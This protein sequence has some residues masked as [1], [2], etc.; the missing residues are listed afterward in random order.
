MCE[1]VAIEGVKQVALL[2]GKLLRVLSVEHG[3]RV[4]FVLVGHAHIVA[5]ARRERNI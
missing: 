1:T 4:S 5:K 3:E 2:E